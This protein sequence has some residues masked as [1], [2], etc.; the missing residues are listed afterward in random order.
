MYVALVATLVFIALARSFSRRSL[1]VND[2]EPLSYSDNEPDEFLVPL[3]TPE[4]LKSTVENA[5][6][7]SVR[8]PAL[9]AE[10]RPCEIA[11]LV[12]GGDATHALIVLAAD[13]M[14][15][16]IRS[17]PDTR[18]VDG[19]C[20]Y[21]KR[22]WRIVVD[23]VKHWTTKKAKETILGNST[24]PLKV[25]KR[26]AFIYRYLSS[27]LPAFVSETIKDP[28]RIKKYFSTAGL[29]RIVSD[30]ASS[31]YR[32]AF[33]QE[34]RQSLLSRGLL[35][36]E[37]QRQKTGRWLIGAGVVGAIATFAVAS[38]FIPNHMVGLIIWIVTIINALVARSLLAARQ[39][40]PLYEELAVV[41]RRIQRKSFRL[42]V[43]RFVLNSI[44]WLLWA[45]F[46]ICTVLTTSI[47]LL[48][49]SLLHVPVNASL[50]LTIGAFLLTN[51]AVVDV[52][53]QAGRMILQECPSPKAEMELA[54][55]RE[56]LSDTRPYK[57]F[58]DF[59]QSEEYNPKLSR[60]LAIYGIETLFILA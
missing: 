37:K 53:F 16:A 39:F 35:V 23:S 45:V 57:A 43:V 29:L 40:I 34:L 17:Q 20:L 54:R 38:L 31:G 4:E 46:L 42:S 55:L 21:E 6:T 41:T 12:R 25:F 60:L 26:L 19:L 28:K 32:Q 48:F 30:F 24:N 14:Q 59:L 22:M 51:F 11:Y 27:S 44:T 49:I 50:F 15:R 2:R 8:V 47:G 36:Q 5:L 18:F 13:L 33:E 52:I 7:V 10:L 3:N 9:S 1:S 56:D 58:Q